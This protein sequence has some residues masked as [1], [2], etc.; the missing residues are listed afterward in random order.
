MLS[1]SLTREL[2]CSLQLLLV[3][4]SAVILVP[5]SR[6]IHDH[7]L[8]SQNYNSSNLEGQVPVFIYPRKRLV[9]LYS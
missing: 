2:A 8:L 7:I 9:Q 4:S 3:L 6:G 1:L 5:E